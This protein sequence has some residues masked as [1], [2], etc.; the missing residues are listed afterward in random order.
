M[1]LRVPSS[2]EQDWIIAE[3]SGTPA[4]GI[5]S[6]HRSGSRKSE[7]HSDK[8]ATFESADLDEIPGNSKLRLAPD[9][10]PADGGGEARGHAAQLLVAFRK[11]AINGRMAARDID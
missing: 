9:E 2:R 6:I 1:S 8:E 4:V 10:V 5:K 3:R 7:R 11:V